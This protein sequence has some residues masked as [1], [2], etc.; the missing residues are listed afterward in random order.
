MSWS[1]CSADAPCAF[2]ALYVDRRL[3]GS[4][5]LAEARQ[6]LPGL[7]CRFVASAAE[8]PEE[9]LNQRTLYLSRPRG[10]T[11]G[12]C[13]GS[14]GQLCCN[15]LTVDLYLGCTLGCAYCIM[16]SYLNFSPVTVYLDPEPALTR[17]EAIA[18]NN[19]DRVVRV[20]TGEVG[21]SLLLDPVFRLSEH[22]IRRLA[23]Y[24]NLFLELKT[25][26]DHVE[27]LLDVEPK[28][29]AVIGFSVNPP[30]MVQA[31]EPGAARLERRLEAARKAIDSGYR[32]SFHFDPIFLKRPQGG[33]AL[34]DYQA[35]A[36]RIAELPA[37]RIAWISLGGF[38][39][40]PGLK[41]RIGELPF[42]Y[43]EFVPGPDGKYRYPQK[44][45]TR[46][47]SAL[48]AELRPLQAVPVYLCMESPAV[49]RLSFGRL[50]AQIP[51]IRGIFRKAKRIPPRPRRGGD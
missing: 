41:E 28:G 20:G 23:A 25:K 19:A 39:Y 36:R 50:P 9:A 3:A 32:V 43:E 49:W 10:R 33:E 40:T 1:S 26:T 5:L 35:L 38:R 48:L 7:P 30:E 8:I 22:L 16:R 21:D 47:Y 46:L 6:R 44:A 31:W 2:D 51:E 24:P 4:P 34:G 42:L 13:P 18:R 27:H 11:V 15:Y 29:N 37:D 45:R 12:R 14:A 17:L